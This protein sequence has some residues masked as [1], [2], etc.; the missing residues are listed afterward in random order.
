MARPDLVNTPYHLLGSWSSHGFPC[1]GLYALTVSV[2]AICQRIGRPALEGQFIQEE[3]MHALLP[4]LA[5]P[6]I[7]GSVREEIERGKWSGIVSDEHQNIGLGVEFEQRANGLHGCHRIIIP[8][9]ILIGR[10]T[11]ECALGCGQH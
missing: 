6:V 10:A 5:L 4:A 9:S 8:G 2:N 7:D 11:I 1:E 3:P